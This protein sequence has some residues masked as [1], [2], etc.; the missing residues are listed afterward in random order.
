MSRAPKETMDLNDI[1]D[2]L[3]FQAVVECAPPQINKH[4]FRGSLKCYSTK[5]S[6]TA[7]ISDE[8]LSKK[9]LYEISLSPKN[10]LLR[11]YI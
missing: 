5:I 3:Q 9:M 7:P 2:I 10:L 11:G 8:E 6:P 4:A 1:R